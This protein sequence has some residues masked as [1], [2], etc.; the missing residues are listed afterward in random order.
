MIAQTISLPKS[1]DPVVSRDRLDLTV[2]DGGAK[3]TASCRNVQVDR[4]QRLV[5]CRF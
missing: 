5:C 3:S 4:Y 2:V 1:V